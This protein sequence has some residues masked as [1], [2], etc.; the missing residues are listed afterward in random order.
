[1]RRTRWDSA[2]W[3]PPV[4]ERASGRGGYDELITNPCS[5]GQAFDA[6]SAEGIARYREPC[7]SVTG[8]EL[9]DIGIA[10]LHALSGPR[11]AWCTNALTVIRP[12]AGRW[13]SHLRCHHQR[14]IEH[15]SPSASEVFSRQSATVIC[16]HGKLG[17]D[18]DFTV[19]V[20]G[21]GSE[22][23]I[24]PPMV[25]AKAHS[26]LAAAAGSCRLYPRANASQPRGRIRR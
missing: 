4:S 25:K 23:G 5:D 7:H 13:R 10:M 15:K 21:T 19:G 22:W 9:I 3:R 14:V 6:S 20:I 1:M 16:P 26:N 2:A 11:S 17:K 8:Y 12:R 18:I 24:K